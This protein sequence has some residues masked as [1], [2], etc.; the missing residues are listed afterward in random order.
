MLCIRFCVAGLVALAMTTS[1]PSSVASEVS[2]QAA[3]RAEVDAWH[4]ARLQRLRAPDGWLSLVGLHWVEEGEHSLGTASDNDIV[5]ATG[6]AHLGRV[7][8]NNGVL[9]V[10]P[11]AE[12]GVAAP[13]ADATRIDIVAGRSSIELLTRGDRRGLRVRD[14]EAKTRT[15]FVGIDRYPVNMAWRVD[16]RFVAHPAGKTMDIA[17]VTGSLDPTGNPGV[18]HFEF[19]GKPYSL[20]ALDGTETQLFLIIADR[21]SGKDTYGAGRMI[22]IDKPVD[23]KAIID[24]NQAYNPPC[25]F[26]AFSTCPLPPPENRLDLA[27][28]A[29]ERKHIGLSQ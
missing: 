6:P 22:Y 11:A 14:S 29:G 25:A 15:G 18:L 13:A 10:L 8:L 12:S 17:N 5:L 28:T 16:A 4:T 9:R 26:T 1:A 19:A 3:H 24:F 21:T 20:E 27:V 23:G 7:S 2:P